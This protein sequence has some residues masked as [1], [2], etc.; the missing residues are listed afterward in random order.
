MTKLR[1]L[2]GGDQPDED[3]QNDDAPL[4]RDPSTWFA[5]QLGEQWQADEP[6]IYRYVGPERVDGP[7]AP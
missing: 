6:G 3:Q 5:Q 1:F 4:A 7:A 2:R